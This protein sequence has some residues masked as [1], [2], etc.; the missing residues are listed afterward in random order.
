MGAR[1][2][3]IEQPR[4]RVHKISGV[5]R[6]ERQVAD[7]G[8]GRQEAIYRWNW[9]G[10]AQ[11]APLLRDFGGDREQALGIVTS[12]CGEPGLDDGGLRWIAAARGLDLARRDIDANYFARRN[13]SATSAA[14]APGPQPQSRTRAPGRRC[15]SKKLRLP[16][17][18][19]RAITATTRSL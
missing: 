16:A 19:R 9:I 7:S 4:T 15:G 12:Q 1:F 5:A 13:E 2:E 8:G 6:D 10:D 14:M 11:P 18:E 3:R 17:R